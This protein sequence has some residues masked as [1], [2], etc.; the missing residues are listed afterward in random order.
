LPTDESAE[1]AEIIVFTKADLE[2]GFVVALIADDNYLALI[3]LNF[4]ALAGGRIHLDGLPKFQ[5]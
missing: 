1:R 5:A 2:S 4:L 3:L